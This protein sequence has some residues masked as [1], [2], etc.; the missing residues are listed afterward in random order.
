MEGCK[1]VRQKRE[2]C[3]RSANRP[4]SATPLCITMHRGRHKLQGIFT[5]HVHRFMND[6]NSSICI[7]FFFW[8][9]WGNLKHAPVFKAS[10]HNQLSH[11]LRDVCGKTHTSRCLVTLIQNPPLRTKKTGTWGIFISQLFFIFFLLFHLRSLRCCFLTIR[12]S[13]KANLPDYFQQRS[14]QRRMYL[15]FKMCAHERH[16]SPY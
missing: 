12:F 16:I 5:N 9:F 1:K 6:E 8:G 15:F 11:F 14:G 2:K 4:P 13:G 3:A 7:F 10:V